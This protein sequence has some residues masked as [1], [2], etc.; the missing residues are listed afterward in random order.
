MDMEVIVESLFFFFWEKQASVKSTIDYCKGIAEAG[1]FVIKETF[2]SQC[3]IRQ[4]HWC[5]GTYESIVIMAR[6]SDSAD[7]SYLNSPS[8][9]LTKLPECNNEVSKGLIQ[10]V[11]QRPYFQTLQLG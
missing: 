3:N 8:S 1:C 5:I 10:S 11:F 7:L 2:H 4:A 6:N 9:F